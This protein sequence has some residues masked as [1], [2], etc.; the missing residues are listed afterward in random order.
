MGPHRAVQVECL[1]I[2]ATGAPGPPAIFNTDQHSRF[3]S[4]AFTDDLNGCRHPDQQGRIIR[5]MH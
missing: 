2:I 1:F 3:T 5:A 4:M